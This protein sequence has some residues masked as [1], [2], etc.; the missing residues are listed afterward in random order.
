MHY[1]YCLSRQLKWSEAAKGDAAANQRITALERGRG[2]WLE[3]CEGLTAPHLKAHTASF[4]TPMGVSSQVRRNE[5]LT[6]ARKSGR[7]ETDACLKHAGAACEAAQVRVLD[8]S[9]DAE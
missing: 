9:T 6:D 2:S 4:E 7:M 3:R 8:V 5:Q 1:S